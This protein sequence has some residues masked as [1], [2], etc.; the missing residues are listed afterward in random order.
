MHLANAGLRALTVGNWRSGNVLG[1]A[2]G[3]PRELVW[4]EAWKQGSLESTASARRDNSSRRVHE[5][6][7]TT[8]MY[9]TTSGRGWAS[10]LFVLQA[11]LVGN[12]F[13]WNTAAEFS[14]TA[15]GNV[16]WWF[17]LYTTPLDGSIT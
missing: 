5:D 1:S 9:C 10:R 7:P 4:R 14:Q 2:G 15:A 11:T 12:V 8:A 3:G 6:F 17:S 16:R 13:S